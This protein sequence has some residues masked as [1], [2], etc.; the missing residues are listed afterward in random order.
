[1]ITLAAMR[2]PIGGKS[3]RS[4]NLKSN[5]LSIMLLRVGLTEFHPWWVL[6]RMMIK[7]QGLVTNN[8]CYSLWKSL[9]Q[10]WNHWTEGFLQQN[11]GHWWRSGS[12]LSVAQ[13]IFGWLCRPIREGEGSKLISKQNVA[14]WLSCPVFLPSSKGLFASALNQYFWDPKSNFDEKSPQKH[15]GN[16]YNY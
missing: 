10:L 9:L 2:K 4:P 7:P 1:M 16:C 8:S 11:R 6:G 3:V 13:V 14:R 15:L 5:S 12:F